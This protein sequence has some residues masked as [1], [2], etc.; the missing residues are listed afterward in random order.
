MTTTTPFA[1]EPTAGR[2]SWRPNSFVSREAAVFV[3]LY[4]GVPAFGLAALA[5]MFRLG[6]GAQLHVYFYRG[7][8]L[9][10]LAFLLTFA[11]ALVLLRRAAASDADQRLFG[12]EAFAVAVLSF[13]LNL[14]FF[15][16]APVT[17]DRSI[18]VFMLGQMAEH[19][20][21]AYS[22]D[23]MQKVF[24]DVYLTDDQQIERRMH[25]QLISR[26][27]E[28]VGADRYRIS[29]RGRAF[30]AVSKLVAGMFDV[31]P[32]FVTPASDP[33]DPAAASENP[34]LRPPSRLVNNVPPG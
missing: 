27:V 5:A 19:P 18:S 9:I 2:L 4:V 24:E 17:L 29:P 3:G 6:V 28:A 30:I 31:D 7:V 26:D 33:A 16:L 34:R 8:V 1:H 32:R 22:A 21:R 15:V 13:G 14:A 23:Q 20:G 25:E 10:G 11:A 12:R